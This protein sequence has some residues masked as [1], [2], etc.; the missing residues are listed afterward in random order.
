MKKP[1]LASAIGGSVETVLD[2]KTGW[3]FKSNNTED[4]ANHISPKPQNPSFI[5]IEVKNK[6]IYWFH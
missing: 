2:K 6:Y 3:L 5:A 1:I 4:L